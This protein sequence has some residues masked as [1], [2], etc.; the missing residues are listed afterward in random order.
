M[1]EINDWRAAE[2]GRT[3]YQLSVNSLRTRPI[4][5]VQTRVAV[6]AEATS[7]AAAGRVAGS[8]KVTGAVGEGRASPPLSPDSHVSSASSSLRGCSEVCSGPAAQTGG[9]QAKRAVGR[10]EGQI[11][12]RTAVA[13]CMMME[14]DAAVG[15]I[16]EASSAG[17]PAN[18]GQG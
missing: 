6:A 17:G 12:P 11:V 15:Q 16:L 7:T 18:R 9:A 1:S 10:V 5:Q 2:K 8:E 14:E 3:T 4:A 13:E